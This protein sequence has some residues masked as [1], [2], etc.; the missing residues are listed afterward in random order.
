MQPTNRPFYRRLKKGHT[1]KLIAKNMYLIR[2]ISLVVCYFLLSCNHQA[3]ATQVPIAKK[4]VSTSTYPKGMPPVYNNF[5][6]LA[7]IFEQQNDTTYLINF[8]ATWC[9]PCVEELPYFEQL[10]KKYQDKKVK[11]ILVSLDFK[12]QLET[13]LLPFIK[14]HQLQSEVLVLLDT[15]ENE[16]LDKVDPS[17]SGAIPAT[18]IYRNDKRAFY[19]A[20]FDDLAA[21]EK[22]LVEL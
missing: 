7:Y 5:D 2:L 8:W 3:P 20:S 17:W 16:W 19:E 4:A 15:N 1:K 18:L 10:T 22:I 12:K 6:E 21:L 11:V 13:K 9:K 14:K